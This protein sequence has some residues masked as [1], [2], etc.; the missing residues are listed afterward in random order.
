MS[1]IDS[2]ADLPLNWSDLAVSGLLPTGTVTLLLADVEGS[3]R[4]WETQPDEMSA[5]VAQF[6]HRISEI[7]ASHGGVRPVEQGE[8]DS[9]VAAFSRAGD[10]VACALELQRES[11]APIRLRI[12]VHTGDIQLRDEGNYTGPTINR[13]ARLR[14][15]AHGGQTVLSGTTSDMVVDRL[16]RDAFLI[17]LG[18]HALR[19][20]PRPERVV[21]LCH[22]D[23]RNHFPPL[24]TSKAVGAPNLP[25]Q[26]TSFIGRGA[27]MADVMRLLDEGRLVTLTG[28]GGAGKTRLAIE[29]AARMAPDCRDG[30]YY[31]DLAPITDP[32]VVPIA[33]ARALALPD[34]PGRS[35]MDALLR[36]VGDRNLLVVLDNCEHLLDAC[37]AL[38]VAILAA[39]PGVTVLATSREPVGVPGE[40]TRQVPSLPLDHEAIEL[41]T[42]RAR[43]ARPDFAVSADNAAM[44]TEICRRLDGLPLAIELAAARVRALSLTEIVASLHDRFRLLTGGARTAVRRQQT[45]RASV[46]WSHALLTEPERV[47][48][49]R[50][51]AFLGGFDLDGAQVVAGGG[52]LQRY[53]VL[54]QLT[55]LVDKS[56]VVA[57]D[58]DGRSRYR[59]LE[60]VRQYALEKLGESGEADAVRARHRDHY[61]AM[62]TR[63][64]AMGRNGNASLLAQVDTEIDNLR[65]AFSWSREQSDIEAALALASALQRLWFGRGRLREGMSWFDALLVDAASDDID[66]AAAVRARALADKALID[67]WMGEWGVPHSVE[68]AR[69]SLVLARTA[70]DEAVL[71]RAL[72]VCAY[73]SGF[74]SEDGQPYYAEAIELVRA[75]GDEWTLSHILTWQ[76]LGGFVAG[77]PEAIREVAEE[78]CEVADAVGNPFA[79]RMCRFYLGWVQLWHGNLAEAIAQFGRVVAESDAASDVVVKAIALECRVQALAYHGDVHEALAVGRETLDVAEEAGGIY[80]GVARCAFAYAALAA[81]DVAAA[82]AASEAGWPAVSTQPDV[83]ATFIVTRAQAR[84]AEG[85][86]TAALRLADDAVASTN[87]WH[88]MVALTVR[89]RVAFAQ[90]KFGQAERDAHA[91]LACGVEVRVSM[92]ISDVFDCLAMLAAESGSHREAVRLLGAAAAMR[93][94]TGEVPFQIYQADYD[95]VILALRNALGDSDFDVAWADGAALPADEA[96]AYAQRGRGERKRPA[97]GWASLTPTELD[98]V[99]LVNEG[100]SNKDI[101]ARLFVSPRTVQTHLT[102]VYNKLGLTSRVQLAQE[103]ARRA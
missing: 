56:L 13:T 80:P 46:D 43:L 22:P 79:A 29:V 5:A 85:D 72:T 81:G 21:Q 54:D 96:T 99:R 71:A 18:V 41:F 53:Q 75:L 88:K 94:R 68:R 1:Q 49:R 76:G 23:L 69:E 30:V 38:V 64:D 7:I 59:L 78:G 36:F 40:V 51:A 33:A 25:P 87:G 65:A 16:P 61:A 12:G 2:P 73:A 44:V 82:V 52:E 17:D 8:G 91:A 100:L 28:A 14:D 55:L 39:A 74:I 60:T 26:L 45:L 86:L 97:H 42:D 20:L 62:A 93:H 103:L 95:A 35:T 92:G 10:A 6:D 27:D 84:L 102:H 15:L 32:D 98:V 67:T 3:T 63:L 90:R 58:S 19:D 31:V 4:L 66:V 89:A 101:G 37:A 77:D 83:A 47:L 11:A 48:F 9:F 50:L 34:Q 70:G 24:R 57:E